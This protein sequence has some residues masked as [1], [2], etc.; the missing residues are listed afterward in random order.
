MANHYV[1]NPIEVVSVGQ[2]VSVKVLDID[3]EREKVSLTMKDQSNMDSKVEHDF[4]KNKKED[5]VLSRDEDDMSSTLKN[6]IIFT[7]V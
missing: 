4:K 3:K 2:R 1:S 7:K 5:V 6:N